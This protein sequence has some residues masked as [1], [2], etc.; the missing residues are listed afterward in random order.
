MTMRILIRGPK[1]VDPT[2]SGCATFPKLLV[3]KVMECGW[4]LLVKQIDTAQTLE[5]V[6][7]VFSKF[8]N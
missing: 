8:K 6:I 2:G 1:T 3:V 7:Q 5:D 4:D